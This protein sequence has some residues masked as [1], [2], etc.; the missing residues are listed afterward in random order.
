MRYPDSALPIAVGATNVSTLSSIV[1]TRGF[2]YAKIACVAVPEVALASATGANK[3]SESDD[4]YT[5]TDIDATKSGTG[6]TPA[7]TVGP[8]AK[9]LVS[10]EVDLR[11][12]KRFLKVDFATAA[13]TQPMIV[14]QFDGGESFNR[15]APILGGIYG[16]DRARQFVLD[17][18]EG[19][20]SLDIIGVG[21]SNQG[22]DNFGYTDGIAYGMIQMGAPVYATPIAPGA[23]GTASAISFFPGLSYG[24]NATNTGRPQ[25]TESTI[26][27]LG[28]TQSYPAINDEWNNDSNGI[29]FGSSGFW[30]W[31]FVNASA[32]SLSA[33]IS[34]AVDAAMPITAEHIWRIGVATFDSGSGEITF[35]VDNANTGAAIVTE[36]FSSNTG[37]I[38]FQPF[39]ITIAADSAR[40]YGLR[41]RPYEEAPVSPA[42]I[43][44]MSVYQRRRGF[45]SNHYHSGAGQ[46]VSQMGASMDGKPMMKTFLT[47]VRA[48]QIAAG[49]SGRVLI[50]M[51]GGVNGVANTADWPTGAELIRNY[52]RTAWL[53]LGY[54]ESDLAFLFSV[55][56]Q[57]AAV[58]DL[59]TA[60]AAAKAWVAGKPD[61]TVYDVAEQSLF[62]VLNN[63]TLLK[64]A[65]LV[66][67]FADGYR[68][69]GLRCIASLVA[70]DVETTTVSI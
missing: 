28:S 16:G 11:G 25:T 32:T 63:R 19:R 26:G 58:D 33:Q 67:M 30:N 69:V 43:L 42:G 18:I 46:T 38:G 45:A 9:P 47:E 54:P 10:Y 7:S 29:I 1:D 68:Y 37:A 57:R 3:L 59:A 65:G 40:N 34:I 8:S 23:A 56:H 70:R 61:A 48:R 66:H 2:R 64:D 60:R 36:T 49:G 62:D 55:T 53:E 35:R 41:L 24:Y 21:D 44:W 13:T 27:V 31:L 22:H 39:E 50:A 15:V 52:W 20:D 14:A 5:F 4:G 51:N 6:F 17:C 12:R